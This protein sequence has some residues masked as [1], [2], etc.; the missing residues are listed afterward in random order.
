MQE[1][2]MTNK[3]R[4]THTFKGQ[5][6][7]LLEVWNVVDMITLPISLVSAGGKFIG[8]E[9]AKEVGEELGE[10]AV[11]EV[12][13]KTADDVIET[14]TKIEGRNGAGLNSVS[15]YK[16]GIENLCTKD[17]I[18]KILDG[19]TMQSTKI[20]NSL[21]TGEIKLNVLGDELFEWYLGVDKSVVA[22]QVG[23][24][25]Y[26]RKGSQSMFSDLVHEGTH[27]IDY[28]NKFGVDGTSRWSWE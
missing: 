3:E 22:L 28:I 10:K 7:V 17:D 19:K 21:K 23:N 27:V 4:T 1:Y 9:V 20:A 16:E 8:K 15:C 11:K 5:M 13:E 26:V 24:Q 2:G 25:I 6:S 18:I 14:V 12:A